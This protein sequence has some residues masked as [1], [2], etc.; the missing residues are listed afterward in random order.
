MAAPTPE[1][2]VVAPGLRMVFGEV[3]ADC[4]T[5][6]SLFARMDARGGAFLLES[7][8]GSGPA[9]YSFFGTSPI[10]R[11]VARG[12]GVTLTGELG[13]ASWRASVPEA[14]RRLGER[15][16]PLPTLPVP[17]AAGAVGYMGYDAVRGLE[18]IGP[19]PADERDIPDAVFIVPGLLYA[20]D[21]VRQTLR[22]TIL[23]PQ[24]R[25][26][27]E[28]G[29]ELARALRLSERPLPV[30]GPTA[31]QTQGG[32]TPDREAFK[33]AVVR[34]KEAIRDGEI[35]QVVLSTRYEA[36]LGLNPFDLYR[37]LRRLN[38]SPYLFYLDFGGTKLVGAS[39][40]ALVTVRGRR[41]TLRPIA[42]TRGRGAGGEEDDRIERE[43]RADEKER[44]EHVMLVDL[45]RND[46]GRVSRIGSVR[47]GPLMAIERYS[48]V[49]HLVS[50]VEGI[51]EDGRDGLDALGAAFPAGTLTGAP[52]IR[53]M[54]IIDRLEGVRRGPYGGAV[55][56][57]TPAGDLDMCIAIRTCVIHGD[58]LYVQ[59]GAGIVADSDPEAEWMECQRKAGALLA[60]L[61]EAGGGR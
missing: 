18:K 41:V 17:F 28:V 5:P 45:A 8:P 47:V 14:L 19:G 15:M 22:A 1:E 11:L 26:Q 2:G 9:R 48:H 56:Y 24:A 21:H 51:L 4:D 57:V 52:K 16:G 61:E 42:G 37:S 40:E 25:P 30:A 23:A 27:E 10:A 6:V 31:H 58:R 60:A 59:A 33:E 29:E 3:P 38:P 7:V 50:G 39:P 43:L 34:A 44:A 46:A 54:E 35:F 53:A 13:H 20:Y 32:F 55:G 12:A 49:M 36:A